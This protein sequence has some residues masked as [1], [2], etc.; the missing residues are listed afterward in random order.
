M[1]W[2][3]SAG[4]MMGMQAARHEAGRFSYHVLCRKSPNE[5][6]TGS[7]SF[8]QAQRLEQVTKNGVVHMAFHPG[9]DRLLIACGDKSGHVGLWDVN[10]SPVA[11]EG[12]PWSVLHCNVVPQLMRVITNQGCIAGTGNSALLSHAGRPLSCR[13][14]ALPLA[15]RP[16]DAACMSAQREDVPA[17]PCPAWGM[18]LG[19]FQ[20]LCDCRQRGW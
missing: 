6:C 10:H 9:C 15:V 1:W 4:K 3:S 20:S 14:A 11:P 16:A 8:T 13:C 18:G 17:A 5:H 2:C 12:M 7:C 19:R